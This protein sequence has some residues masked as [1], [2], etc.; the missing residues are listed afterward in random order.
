MS[1]VVRLD[2][3]TF[4]P[5]AMIRHLARTPDPRVQ[6]RARQPCR[7]RRPTHRR[8]PL[9]RGAHAPSQAR[10][11]GPSSARDV[12]RG[13]TGPLPQ[14]V[15]RAASP[16]NA[17][18]GEGGRRKAEGG[19]RKA[20]GGRQ[21][22][23]GVQRKAEVEP[24]DDPAMRQ[25]RERRPPGSRRACFPRKPSLERPRRECATGEKSWC[26]LRHGRDA[27]QRRLVGERAVATA[28]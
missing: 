8:E 15:V 1:S 17:G 18:L 9:P 24:I 2:R 26:H 21:P 4:S 12:T 11:L 23:A 10:T 3:N 19:R 16:L 7:S 13:Y 28:R 22:T 27:Y 20:E 6:V 25:G 14:S 5:R